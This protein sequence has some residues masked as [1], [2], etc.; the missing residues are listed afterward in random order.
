MMAGGRGAGWWVVSGVGC[1][2]GVVGGVGWWVEWGG[3]WSGV[4]GVWWVE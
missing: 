3:E 1:V 4:G 2:V